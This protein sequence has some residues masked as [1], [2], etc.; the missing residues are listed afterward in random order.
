MPS[1]RD[2]LD[3]E[4]VRG[5]E[6]RVAAVKFKDFT[7]IGMMHG[8]AAWSAYAVAEF[9]CAP[10]LFRLIRPY[11]TFTSWHWKLN[12]A[13]IA[14]Y[15]VAGAVAGALAGA[16]VYFLNCN[17]TF[18]R[19]EDSSDVVGLAATFTLVLAFA[20]NLFAS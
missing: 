1:L 13:L 9:V 19:N 15:F 4:W 17:R 7:I 2:R 8:M 16:G 12:A 18:I 10:L 3:S 11:A 20:I 5:F 14:A 6:S